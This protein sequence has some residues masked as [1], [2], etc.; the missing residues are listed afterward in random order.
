LPFH[1]KGTVNQPGSVTVNGKPATVAPDP[2]SST[3]GQIFTATVSLPTG[4]TTM[5]IV[6]LGAGTVSGGAAQKN[7]SLTVNGGTSK[8][9]G[10]DLNGN[11]T[12]SGS[13]TYEW[14]AENRL[15]AINNGTARTELTTKPLPTAC[16]H[17]MVALARW[18]VDSDKCNSQN[19]INGLLPSKRFQQLTHP[20]ARDD[21]F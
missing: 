10:Y 3:G 12:T 17:S 19:C 15:T 1:F 11:C 5:P 8:I 9:F 21:D 6:A 16:R 7:Y 18:Q 20:G 4:A 14:D 13:V 2:T